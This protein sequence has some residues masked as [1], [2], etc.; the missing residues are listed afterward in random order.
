MCLGFCS[1]RWTVFK[2]QKQ[3]A[4]VDMCA[5]ILG[6]VTRHENQ[7]DVNDKGSLPI[8]E[9]DADPLFI[10]RNAERKLFLF[11]TSH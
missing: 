7:P 3:V 8:F 11:I 2:T 1:G 4:I 6:A 10:F 5:I 9:M